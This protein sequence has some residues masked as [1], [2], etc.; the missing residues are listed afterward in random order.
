MNVEH[1]QNDPFLSVHQE[2]QIVWNSYRGKI[3]FSVFVFCGLFC[4]AL[5]VGFVHE[6][7]TNAKVDAYFQVRQAVD[8]WD[9]DFNKREIVIRK[10]EEL[11]PEWILHSPLVRGPYLQRKIITLSPVEILAPFPLDT[12]PVLKEF[13]EIT[14]LALEEKWEKAFAQGELFLKTYHTLK[15]FDSKEQQNNS[16]VDLSLDEMLVPVQYLRQVAFAREMKNSAAEKKAIEAVFRAC[17][18]ENVQ[19]FLKDTDAFKKAHVMFQYC[20][21]SLSQG[22]VSLLTYFSDRFHSL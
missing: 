4:V 18:Y 20:F 21:S 3:I 11:V 10:A 8:L 17:S 15:L 22:S 13:Q 19:D 12:F 7:R 14:I 16:L 9:V 1:G 2:E 5:T 6:R